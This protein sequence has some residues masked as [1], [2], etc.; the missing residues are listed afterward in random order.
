MI[1]ITKDVN[2]GAKLIIQKS[3]VSDKN[4]DDNYIL[5]YSAYEKNN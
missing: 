5:N 1:Y 2:E 4:A 3:D